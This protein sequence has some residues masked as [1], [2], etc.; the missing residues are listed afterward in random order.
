MWNMKYV[1]LSCDLFILPYLIEIIN[2]DEF[3]LLYTDDC[4]PQRTLISTKCS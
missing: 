2:D 1:E 3:T 4:S